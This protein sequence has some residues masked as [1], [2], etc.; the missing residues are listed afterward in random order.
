MRVAQPFRLAALGLAVLAAAVL[1]FMI[2]VGSNLAFSVYD[3]LAAISPWLALSYGIA[4]LA[5]ALSAGIVIW[6]LLAPDRPGP[7][8]AGES[9]DETRLRS[10]IE[11]H[12][13][14]GVVTADAQ[15][16]L[17]ELEQR[18]AG[19][20]VYVA[21]F[22]EISHG[23]SS[24]IRALVPDAELE[25]DVRGG[26]TRTV[27]HYVWHTPAGDRL[28]LADVPGVNVSGAPL[29]PEAEQEA[30]RAHLVIYLCDGDLTR[31]QWQTVERLRRF[32][33]P[34]IMALNKKDRYSETDLNTVLERLRQ[35]IGED[36]PVIAIGT[37]GREEVIRVLSDG[38]EERVERER[39]A[40]VGALVVTLQSRL[41]E[42]GA[43]LEQ[44]RD[45]A[46]F[47]LAAEKLHQS[48]DG[49]R[50]R[51]AE[52]VV[53]RYTRR[54]VIG[55][56]A[57]FAPGADLVIQGALAVALV[58]AL[59]GLYEVPVRDVEIERLIKSASKRTGKTVPLLL[60]VAGNALKAFPG[61]GT[62][63]GGLAHAIAYGLLFQSLGRALSETLAEQGRWDSDEA[64]KAFEEQLSEDLGPRARDL[65]RMAISYAR[66][67][68]QRR[69]G[70]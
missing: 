70:T 46:V 8:P 19:G 50:R 57:A 38:R 36:T 64:M 54:A 43:V 59:C 45:G 22:G 15:A 14:V 65:A 44:L 34:L 21:L 63:A 52:E 48:L 25:V 68:I 31:D 51:T 6:R 30:L 5:F 67:R 7:A 16:E 18:R 39:P 55:G 27:R 69:S 61:T 60:A 1:V 26:T 3:R 41:L 20:D 53:T 29:Q 33:K 11:R 23:K 13:A 58:R 12:A 28:M 37:G 4:L 32:R 47:L 2:L 66:E 35:H 40:D 42:Q 56:L 17:Q 49:Y 24:L 9:S 62:L 10:D